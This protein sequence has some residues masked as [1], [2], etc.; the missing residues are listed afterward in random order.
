M[1]STVYISKYLNLISEWDKTKIQL[2]RQF[3][4]NPCAC[5]SLFDKVT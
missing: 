5:N 2:W 1:I 4:G 3:L